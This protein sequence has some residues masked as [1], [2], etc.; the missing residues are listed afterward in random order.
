MYISHLLYGVD[1]GFFLVFGSVWVSD[2]RY[3]AGY[4]RLRG[5]NVNGMGYLY[6]TQSIHEN[7]S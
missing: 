2:G 1:A 3:E 5:V 4:E 6:N 7:G